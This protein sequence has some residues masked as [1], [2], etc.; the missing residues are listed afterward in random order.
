MELEVDGLDAKFLADLIS[1]FE[2]VS[3]KDVEYLY[4]GVRAT[5]RWR[6]DFEAA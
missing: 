5:C 2:D 6:E 1:V 3:G 4:V